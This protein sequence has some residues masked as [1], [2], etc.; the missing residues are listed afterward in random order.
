MT[1]LLEEIR[2]LRFAIIRLGARLN[3]A[4]PGG[5]NWGYVPWPQNKLY[6]IKAICDDIIRQKLWM[7]WKLAE[8]ERMGE[9]IMN[10]SEDSHHEPDQRGG[11]SA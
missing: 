8:Q 3:A 10:Q 9:V 2:E 4:Q 5:R 11:N 1:D 6:E 7:D